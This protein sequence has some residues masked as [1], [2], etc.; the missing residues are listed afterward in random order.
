ML[1]FYS[2]FYF[3]L[4]SSTV[5]RFPDLTQNTTSKCISTNSINNTNNSTSTFSMP[6]PI[7]LLLLPLLRLHQPLHRHRP[8]PQPLLLQGHTQHPQLTPHRELTHRQEHTVLREVTAPHQGA[9]TPH[10]GTMTPHLEATTPQQAMMHLAATE[11]MIHP[12]LTQQR[13]ATPHPHRMSRHPHT[14]NLCPSA[15]ITLTTRQNPLIDSPTPTQSFHTAD[16]CVCAC[17]FT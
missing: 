17:V 15:M 4:V 16:V 13:E 9:T 10:R 11:H 3:H 7:L 2:F 8:P 5:S 14:G 6:T 1:H 12:E